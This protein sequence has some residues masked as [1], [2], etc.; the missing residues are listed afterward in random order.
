MKSSAKNNQK[1]LP[2]RTLF[3][4]LV[5]PTT[6]I[7]CHLKDLSN[8]ASVE[9]FFVIRFLLD[10]GYKDS[11]I[12]TKK[13]LR[14]LTVARGHKQ[15]KYKPDY[16]LK[17]RGVPR[18][19][20]DAKGVEEDV[21]DWVEQCSG[22]CL[23]LNRK[24]PSS[25]P[26]RYFILSNGITTKVYEWD[27]DEPLLILDFADFRF[28]NPKYEQVKTLLGPHSISVSTPL[29]SAQPSVNFRF[30]RATSE[31][32][33][34]LFATCH[35]AIW[36]S[37]VCGPAP[38]F[39][40]FVKVMFVKLWTDR[41]LRENSATREC[42]K[43]KDQ[44]IYLPNSVVPFSVEW[45]ETREK[46]GTVNPVDTILFARLRDDIELSIQERK[47]KRIFNKDEHIRLKPDTIKD[48][49]RRLQHYDLFGIDEDLNGRLFETFLSATM[50]GRDLGQ[51]FTPRSVVRMMA[52]LANLEATRKQQTSI[53]DACCG[54]G[55]FLIEAL[56]IMRNQVRKNESLSPVEKNDLLE[57]I[58]N[59]CLYGIDV[60]KDPPLARIARMNMSLHGDG[61]SRIYFADALDKELLP[62]KDEDAELLQ[63]RTE[64]RETL[65]KRK[66]DIALTNPP[67]SM[68][69]E[70]KNEAERRILI[71]YDLAKR[72]ETSSTI[73]PS[74][75]SSAMFI[76]R[77]WDL[78]QPG[79][80]LITVI[81][82]TLLASSVDVFKS[83][84]NFIRTRFLVRA[85]ISLPGDAFRRSG[86]RVK[87]SVLV[88]EKKR[89]VDEEQ[90]RCFGFFS[91]HLG[92]D[93]LTP[94]A[95]DADILEARTKAEK[96][97]DT[98]L[99]GYEAYLV[100]KEDDTKGLVLLPERLKDRFDLK[101]CAPEF[102]RMAI[103]WRHKGI[104]VRKLAEI[105][106]PVE[107]LLIPKEHPNDEFKLIKVSYCGRCELEKVRKGARIKAGK[108]FQV[109]AGQLVFSTIR[110]TD[111][112]VGIVPNEFDGALVSQSYTVFECNSPEDTAYLWAILRS[113]ELRADMQSQSPGSGRYTTYWPEIGELLIPWVD[114][115]KR[116]RIGRGLLN[117]WEMERRTVENRH[118]VMA[119]IDVL[120]VESEE[121]KKRF[122][123]SKAP[124]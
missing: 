50:R 5:E 102:G 92:V 96:E 30:E 27:K 74:L 20:V 118:K 54:S 105:V 58:C 17:V 122:K 109:K 47:K 112:A 28:G 6:N 1:T 19:I 66:F 61:G 14:V 23:A 91:Q 9:T 67:F 53:V 100:G 45:I 26:V 37:E 65:K 99:A 31:K 124:T 121:S 48:V 35:K 46:E 29:V 97:T 110:A 36:K 87:T 10:L 93:D 115:Q 101:Y 111:G 107:N 40:E 42:F 34:Q 33:R 60:G 59:D 113:H 25:N 64:L 63:N 119:E 89:D 56:T 76:E 7:Y 73:R 11:Q 15:E 44:V 22:Y 116:K 90:P 57:R 39:M 55:G 52:L 24:F 114:E 82:D 75:R 72:D 32:A 43:E 120:G 83:V 16:A 104:E 69:K 71:Q 49:T 38:A 81:D 51:F 21:D 95:S 4:T 13:S 86:S 108:M 94:R 12:E 85:I 117:T 77:Y 84:R 98:I 18:C 68:S 106:K 3:D 2:R 88:L 123:A 80:K 70:E 8:E 78:L 41:N 62:T 79:G 103:E